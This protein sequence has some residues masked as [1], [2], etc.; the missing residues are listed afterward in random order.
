M[1]SF[2]RSDREAVVVTGAA[3][4]GPLVVAVGVVFAGVAFGVVLVLAGGFVFVLGVLTAGAP[5][6]VG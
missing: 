4:T 1:S 2:G 3:D 5:K 6:A